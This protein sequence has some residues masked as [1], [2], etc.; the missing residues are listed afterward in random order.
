MSNELGMEALYASAVGFN[1]NK[2]KPILINSEES[3][4]NIEKN[5]KSIENDLDFLDTYS[6]LNDKCA[7]DKIRMIT[8]LNNS[9]GRFNK[10]LENYCNIKS[11]EAEAEKVE[12]TDNKPAEEAGNSSTFGQKVKAFFIKI[13]S[14]IKQ[15]F[16]MIARA[17][18]NIARKIADFFSKHSGKADASKTTDIKL[19]NI[20]VVPD[21]SDTP[22]VAS[23]KDNFKKTL[24]S[25]NEKLKAIGA[26]T[27]ETATKAANTVKSK[28]SEAAD[29]IKK[30]K[31]AALNQIRLKIKAAQDKSAANKAAKKDAEAKKI[32]STVKVDYRCYNMSGINYT[33]CEAFIQWFS[34]S[35]ESID[36]LT[37]GLNQLNPG[38][39]ADTVTG[40][41]NESISNC[42]KQ[43]T[44]F[45]DFYA[46]TNMTQIISEAC[47][48]QTKG[49]GFGGS[50]VVKKFINDSKK[51]QINYEKQDYG[52]IIFNCPK[53]KVPE[54]ITADKLKTAIYGD[55]SYDEICKTLT[56]FDKQFSTKINN[57]IGHI[58]KTCDGIE[59][60][61]DQFEK[62]SNE[63]IK[64]DSKNIVLYEYSILKV[65]GKMFNIVQM[66]FG[67]V[68]RC[69]V[70]S[71]RSIK[72]IESTMSK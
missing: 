3:L 32:A 29:K 9:Y 65:V 14:K 42:L 17:I 18:S 48:T 67:D 21:K 43:L 11:L 15:F 60:S 70:Q 6:A 50:L 55:K 66:T 38:E 22:E 62:N 24:D 57:M 47:E 27:K 8:R 49:S 52:K 36:K 35:I 33:R 68:N 46:G 31:D 54:A 37:A 7:N 30:E 40:M 41:I 16:Q 1:S 13:G 72:G 4:D 53:I 20:S 5:I 10:S 63:K 44:N 71:T 56:I 39:I 25:F 69:A 2:E 59:K 26:E 12:N 34:K 28:T 45:K 61:I 58:N 23:L 64:E 19:E 51:F